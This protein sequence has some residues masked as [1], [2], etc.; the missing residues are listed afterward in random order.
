MNKK[1]MQKEYEKY[2]KEIKEEKYKLRMSIL[3]LILLCLFIFVVINYLAN[4]NIKKENENN[5]IEKDS[6]VA[7]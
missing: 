5:T 1:K 7:E 3:V 6:T 2:S 4:E